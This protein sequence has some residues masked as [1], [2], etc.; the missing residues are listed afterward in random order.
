MKL[1]LI[2]FAFIP[3]LAVYCCFIDE[4]NA[5]DIHSSMFN[6]TPM[7]LSPGLIGV[8]G[9]DIRVTTNYR[10][11]WKNVPVDYKTFTASFEHKLFL[12][13]AKRGFFTGGLHFNYDDAGDLSLGQ[14]QIGLSGSYVHPLTK[15]DNNRH[16]LSGGV[17]VGLTQRSFDSGNLRTGLQFNG[18]TYDPNAAT[19]EEGIF[20]DNIAYGSLSGGINYRLQNPGDGANRRLRLDLGGAIYHLMRSNKSLAF[21]Q[22]YKLDRRISLYGISSFQVL[23]T[24]DLGVLAT[25]QFQGPHKEI[26][27]GANVRKYFDEVSVLL[28]LSYRANDQDAFYPNINIDYRNFSFGFSYDLNISEFDIATNGRGGPEL[29]AIFTIGKPRVEQRKPCTIF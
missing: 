18:D 21:N 5:Q 28:G 23:S 13:G 29:S 25:G 11:Q 12:Q 19:G 26:V 3:I 7:N 9:G 15:S 8:F 27:I 6:R 20:D 16:F 1:K 2:K 4:I 17:Q 22:A 14:N 10:R 24:W